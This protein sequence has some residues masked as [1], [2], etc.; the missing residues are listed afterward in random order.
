MRATEA[1]RFELRLRCSNLRCAQKA[2]P[3]AAVHWE[4]S[5]RAACSWGD[6]PTLRLPGGEISAPDRPSVGRSPHEQAARGE[7]PPTVG[8]PWGGSLGP[9]GT[10]FRLREG[11]TLGA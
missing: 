1:P 5:L 7:N 3:R 9:F 8:R 2:S 10:V 11:D 6:L 4:F